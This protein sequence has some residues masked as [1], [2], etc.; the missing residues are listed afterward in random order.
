MS[1]IVRPFAVGDGAPAPASPMHTARFAPRRAPDREPERA[2]RILI[3]DDD[4]D[5]L[6]DLADCLR[7]PACAI[8]T[9]GQANAFYEKFAQARPDIVITDLA[10]PSHDGTDILRWLQS[11]R[12]TGSVILMSGSDG[13]VLETTRRMAA[14]YGLNI[15]G[16]LRK[17]FTPAQIDALV[18][19]TLASRSDGSGTAVA[20]A[21]RRI[22]PYFQPKIDL[23][24]GKIAGA[25]ALS[26][27]WHPESGLLAPQGY[28][29]AARAAGTQSLHDLTIL[30]RALEFGGKLNGIGYGMS[31]A[32][33]FSAEVI[34]GDHFLEVVA[35]AQQR[36][37]TEPGQLIVELTENEAAENGELVERLLKLRLTGVHLSIDDF[38]TGYS[39]LSRIQQLPASE[40]KIDRSFING[41]TEYSGNF[42]I[43]RSIVDLAHSLHCTA[44]AEG[45]ET[46][47]TLEALTKLGCDLAQGHLFSP[48]VNEQ[49]FIA[50]VRDNAASNPAAH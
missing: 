10:M 26:R 11:Q 18:Q 38:G 50:L 41:L 1:K 46:L 20:L 48:A 19:S 47:E 16:T 27:W 37:G 45:V 49:T 32:V 7:N 28:L 3:I 33:N 5:L 17:P 9:A 25:E 29:G 43:V 6:A 14:S 2:I 8:E 44:V 12:F 36:H 31:I 15:A 24:T 22:R 40:I 23:K 34:L 42:A 13:H 30:E 21:D 4:G 39:S 35:D